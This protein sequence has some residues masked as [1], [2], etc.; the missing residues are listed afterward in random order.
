MPVWGTGG[1]WFE[2]SHPDL[3]KQWA[4]LYESLFCFSPFR[5]CFPFFRIQSG[6]GSVITSRK[7]I[8]TQ[9]IR[10]LW[11]CETIPFTVRNHTFGSLKPMVLRDERIRVVYLLI[12]N[13]LQRGNGWWLGMNDFDNSSNISGAM[14]REKQKRRMSSQGIL[15]LLCLTPLSAHGR[16]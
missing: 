16:W 8:Y 15:R 9:T 10:N 2:S 5:D 13:D 3:H 12:L 7:Y 4:A 14:N 6:G 11:A 1:R